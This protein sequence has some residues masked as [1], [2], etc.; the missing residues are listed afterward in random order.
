MLRLCYTP[1]FSCVHLFVDPNDLSEESSDPDE[2]VD[3]YDED[4]AS[5]ADD[6]SPIDNTTGK[7]CYYR[8]KSCVHCCFAFYIV[9]YFSQHF[10][11]G[12]L[13]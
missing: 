6:E 13:P 5:E 12:F 9:G 4:G 8:S 11:P 7:C 3:E 10:V 1:C 2:E